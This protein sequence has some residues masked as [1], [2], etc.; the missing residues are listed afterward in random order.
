VKTPVNKN[1]RPLIWMANNKWR[2]TKNR[3]KIWM[4]NNK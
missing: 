2:E 3:N 4:G 1:N